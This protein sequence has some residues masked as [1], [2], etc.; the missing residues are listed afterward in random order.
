MIESSRNLLSQQ[1][2][3]SKRAAD[4]LHQQQA[5]DDDFADYVGDK[6][7]LLFVEDLHQIGNQGMFEAEAVGNR[8]NLQVVAKF[9]GLF[10]S[11]TILSAISCYLN[12]QFEKNQAVNS[13]IIFSCSFLG[14]NFVLRPLVIGVMAVCR[15]GRRRDAK[16][17]KVMPEGDSDSAAAGITQNNLIQSTTAITQVQMEGGE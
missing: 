11:M 15:A 12:Y 6:D 10:L 17:S 9:V 3:D 2:S 4:A 1:V 13:F 16:E 5:E 8:V 14:D 7:R